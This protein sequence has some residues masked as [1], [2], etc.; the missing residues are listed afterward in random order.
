VDVE[1]PAEPSPVP[2][3][4]IALVAPPW[5]PVPP[6]G[7]GG[8]ERVCYDLAQGLV[9][10]GHAVTL[11]ACGPAGT[12]ADYI[13]VFEQPPEGLGEVEGPVQEV[14]YGAAV[15]RKLAGIRCDLVHDHSLAAPLLAGGRPQPTVI[16]AHGPTDNHV[17]DYYRQLGL[18]IVATSWAQRRHA[19]D[20]PWIAT[21]HNGIPV[22]EYPFR[23]E[24]DDYVLFMARL[25]PEKGAHLAV[26]AARAAGVRLVLAGAPRAPVDHRYLEE[27][28]LPRLGPLARCIGEVGG[29]ERDALLAGARCV[30]SPVQWEEP[31]GLVNVEALACG[32]PV[33]AC[34]RGALPE[35][36]THG[37]TGVLGETVDDLAAALKTIDAIDPAVCR[38]DALARFDTAVMVAGYERVYAEQLGL[39]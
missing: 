31:F 22:D 8:I 32:T 29:A 4:R 23:S 7:Y 13:P 38:A 37:V 11:L 28:V 39:M 12:R 21:V 18:P 26:E 10:R 34:P 2:A 33:V 16:S 36:V 20:L 35:V 25:S 15:G 5:Y 27:E 30:I 24:K 19:P 17:G 14:R 6:R 3:M 9:A 1:Q